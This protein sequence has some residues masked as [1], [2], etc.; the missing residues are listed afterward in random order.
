[1]HEWS[2]TNMKIFNYNINLIKWPRIKEPVLNLNSQFL[3][4]I[5]L[6]IFSHDKEIIP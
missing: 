3:V 4:I 6:L 1:M 2:E 5:V